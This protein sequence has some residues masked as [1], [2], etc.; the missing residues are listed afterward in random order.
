MELYFAR[1]TRI[2]IEPYPDT[3]EYVRSDVKTCEVY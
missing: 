3:K 1:L 2:N